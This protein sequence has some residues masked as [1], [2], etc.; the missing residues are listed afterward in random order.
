[1]DLP[2]ITSD[3][4][5]GFCDLTFA[6]ASHSVRPDGGHEIVARGVHQGALVGFT[7]FILPKWEPW[8]VEG[9]P[10]PL[11]RGGVVLGPDGAAGDEFLKTMGALYG[12]EDAPLRMAASVA[13]TAIALGG[14]PP[15]LQTE[16]VQLKLF[17]EA[18]FTDERYAEVY[19]NVDLA[20]ARLEFREKDPDY[21]RPLLGALS[22]RNEAA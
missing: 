1:M 9:I 14:Y 6:V 10:D 17:F 19:L 7:V 18:D 15:A 22:A 20:A 3:S 5:D 13:F 4:E 16:A 12:T 21:R 8:Q 2:E 11:Y